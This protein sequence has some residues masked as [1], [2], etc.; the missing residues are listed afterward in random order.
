MKPIREWKLVIKYTLEFILVVLGVFLGLFLN[1]LSENKSNRHLAQ[2]CR[3]NFITEIDS[4]KA[5]LAGCYATHRAFFDTIVYLINAREESL[6]YNMSFEI[7][8]LTEASWQTA[9]ATEGM[10]YLENQE[11]IQLSKCYE[12]QEFLKG[13]H[14]KVLDMLMS[15]TLIEKFTNPGI[16]RIE[17]QT[18]LRIIL[19]YL[20]NLVR[21]EKSMLDTYDE[22]LTLLH[23]GKQ[24]RKNR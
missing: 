10:I 16:S 17:I 23:A 24:G 11:V 13:I 18:E 5:E 2:T 14:Q 15:R 12:V 3:N 7:P 20:G 19:S 4:N 6:F 9:V 8:D 21:M 22:P 1:Q